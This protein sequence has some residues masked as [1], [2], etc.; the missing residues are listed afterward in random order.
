M[1][2]DEKT[3]TL[4]RSEKDAHIITNISKPRRRNSKVSVKSK[5]NRSEAKSVDSNKKVDIVQKKLSVVD[6]YTNMK[7]D[8]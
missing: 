1:Y 8:R 5:G 6:R 3:F 2:F 4:P 7:N